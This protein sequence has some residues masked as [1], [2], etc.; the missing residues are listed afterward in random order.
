MSDTRINFTGNSAGG[1][2]NLG[3]VGGSIFSGIAA[4]GFAAEAGRSGR[5]AG[6]LGFGVDIIDFRGRSFAGQK[7]LQE[8]LIKVR[9]VVW[10][11]LGVTQQEACWQDAGDGG[12]AV[13]PHVVDAETFVTDIMSLWTA[14]LQEDNEVYRDRVRVRLAVHLAI[15]SLSGGCATGP[16]LIDLADI[17]DSTCLRAAAQARP[18]ADVVC[19]FSEPAHE[20][21][22]SFIGPERASLVPSRRESTCRKDGRTLVMHV[23]G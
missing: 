10:E 15:A 18:N 11:R 9:G 8:R 21:W 16:L 13:F 6:L 5:S 19:A 4:E 23:M 3:H 1:S 12:L 20:A 7:V 17:L 2:I 14:I 22:L